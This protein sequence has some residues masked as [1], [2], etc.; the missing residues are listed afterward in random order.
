[1]TL[2]SIDDMSRKNARELVNKLRKQVAQ[3]I[4]PRAARAAAIAENTQAITMQSLFETWIEFVKLAKEIT[5]KWM[6]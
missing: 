1:M 4:A 5:L 3:G 6:K 2:G